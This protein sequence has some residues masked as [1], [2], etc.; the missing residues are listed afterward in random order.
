[1]ISAIGIR[2]GETDLVKYAQTDQ[3]FPKGTLLV[4][5]DEKG[6]HLAK[7]WQVKK[8]FSESSL[9]KGLPTVVRL[10]TAM[11][12]KAFEDNTKF[13]A[14]S[15]AEVVTLIAK[16]GLDMKLIDIVFPLDRHYVLITFSAEERVDFRQLLKDL[17]AYF[18]TRI[19]LHQI[20][21]REE[22]KIYGGLGPCGRPLCCSSFL[23]EFPAVSI[24][25]LKNQGLSLNSGKSTG[26]CGRLLCCLQYEESFYQES[27]KK[28]PD[29]GT[30]VETSD[31]PATVAAIDI[32]T[33][34]VKVRLKDQLTLV[35][36]A[37]EEVKVGE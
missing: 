19:E 6:N 34:T 30:I 26:Y 28:F 2:Y 13:A 36:Y 5:K 17:A 9:P 21:S 4:V 11:D 8:A 29:Y 27:K 35:T 25:M 3:E 23:G 37:L 14:A 12:K 32:F 22:A 7:V 33:D 31:G 24:K 20:N 1:M 18:K 10:A 15:K 16:N